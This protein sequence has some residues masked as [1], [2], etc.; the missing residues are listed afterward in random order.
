MENS[1][2]N[3]DWSQTPPIL[4]VKRRS[5]YLLSATLP[6]LGCWPLLH[7]L[8]VRFFVQF[9]YV[10]FLRIAWTIFS[11]HFEY[12]KHSIIYFLDLLSI[13]QYIWININE[14]ILLHANRGKMT[15]RENCIVSATCLLITDSSYL[16]CHLF[17]NA[18]CLL[19]A[20]F[21]YLLPTA[22]F[23]QYCL[24]L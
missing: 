2:R 6:I 14:I 11:R 12:L 8:K 21:Y 22:L 5:V 15:R 4:V 18:F 23:H 10:T 13:Q 9:S 20:L 7:P 17:F 1:H 24:Q 3:A 19:S 16:Y